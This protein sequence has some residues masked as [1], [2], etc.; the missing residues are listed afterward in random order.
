KMI[1]SMMDLYDLTRDDLYE[2][3]REFL[4]AIDYTLFISN[5]EMEKFREGGYQEGQPPKA[6]R[7]ERSQS[8]SCI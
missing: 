5:E 6:A 7:A 4:R 2:R 1:Q 3:E 8:I